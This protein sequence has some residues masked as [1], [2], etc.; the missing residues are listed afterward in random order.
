MKTQLSPLHKK[1]L[2]QIRKDL[3]ATGSKEGNF[4]RVEL[5]FYQTLA[6]AKEYG[7]DERENGFLAALKQVQSNEYQQTKALFK[8]NTQRERVIARFMSSLK[9][10]L[11]TGVRNGFLHEQVSQ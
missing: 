3:T 1:Q 2:E 7:T 4:V 10:V 8:K 9:A 5:L 6:I 11:S